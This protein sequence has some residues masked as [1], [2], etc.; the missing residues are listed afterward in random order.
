[1]WGVLEGKLVKFFHFSACKKFLVRIISF[2]SLVFLQL[3]ISPWIVFSI[4][5]LMMNGETSARDLES[6]SVLIATRK[7]PSG[8]CFLQMSGGSGMMRSTNF[9]TSL[10]LPKL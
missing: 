4:V 1:M 2:P 8:R 7:I 3:V 10:K 5:F 6:S 9:K